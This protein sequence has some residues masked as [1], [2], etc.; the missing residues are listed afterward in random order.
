MD[1][2]YYG[3]PIS[4]ESVAGLKAGRRYEPQSKFSMNI[5]F[6]GERGSGPKFFKTKEELIAAARE[7]GGGEAGEKSYVTRWIN[8]GGAHI[9]IEGAM[10]GEVFPKRAPAAA[11]PDKLSEGTKGAYPFAEKAKQYRGYRDAELDYAAKDASDAM[12]AMKDHD[13]SAE[14]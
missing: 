9:S 4:K 10:Y 14:N 11:D 1:L 13:P 8:D 2:G 6:P 12:A 7:M 5:E 3:T